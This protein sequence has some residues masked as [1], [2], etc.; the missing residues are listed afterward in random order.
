M[1]SRGLFRSSRGPMR[2]GDVT[3]RAFPKPRL[4]FS[5]SAAPNLNEF[6]T[7]FRRNHYEVSWLSNLLTFQD[8]LGKFLVG[9]FE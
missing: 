1:M 9:V 5:H 6:A 2:T 4:D 3:A 8:H 7:D